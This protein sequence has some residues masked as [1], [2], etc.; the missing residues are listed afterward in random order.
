MDKKFEN[1]YWELGEYDEMI[2]GKLHFTQYYDDEVILRFQQDKDDKELFWYA[3]E[4]L[5]VEQDCVSIDSKYFITDEFESM[6]ID[7]I[8][9][10]I[11]ELEDI[12]EKFNKI[13]L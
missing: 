10:K 3:S 4:F 13:N 8:D 5:K 1:R 7:Y 11:S 12:K 6:I 9:E 2:V